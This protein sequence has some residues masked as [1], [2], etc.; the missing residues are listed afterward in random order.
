MAIGQ[1]GG[2]TGGG[3]P[4]IPSGTT[5]WRQAHIDG[6]EAVGEHFWV[7]WLQ[8]LECGGIPHPPIH[9]FVVQTFDASALTG[10]VVSL[11]PDVVPLSG[12]RL[13]GGGSL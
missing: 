4:F 10:A 8:W 13:Q 6:R 11:P 9:C 3:L 7:Q 2:W 12:V 5:F 1:G